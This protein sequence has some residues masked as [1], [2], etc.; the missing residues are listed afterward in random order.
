MIAPISLPEDFAVAIWAY[1][2]QCSVCW[3][4]E[5]N[6]LQYTLAECHFPCHPP[7][8]GCQYCT[9]L[10][11]TAELEGAGALRTFCQ[12][13]GPA[14]ALEAGCG[15]APVP[16]SKRRQLVDGMMTG[17]RGLM[18]RGNLTSCRQI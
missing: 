2:F 3:A 9:N 17:E 8:F 7:F 11:R 5:S 13:T 18:S 12:G 4:V 14:A 6:F 1:T 16:L 15:S 10:F